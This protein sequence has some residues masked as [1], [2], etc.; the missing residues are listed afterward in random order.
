MDEER[1]IILV[2]GHE[3]LHNSQHS[4][5]E[6]NL[7]KDN[8]WKD[9]A[10][11]IHTALSGNG[12]V[13]AGSRHGNG[14][15]CVNWPLTRQGNGMVCLNRPL[16]SQPVSSCRFHQHRLNDFQQIEE[17]LVK[18]LCSTLSISLHH[19]VRRISTAQN[20]MHGSYFSMS[21]ETSLPRFFSTNLLQQSFLASVCA[22]STADTASPWHTNDLAPCCFLFS[23]G[24][25]ETWAPR[26]G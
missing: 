17:L 15:V 16:G 20:H 1:L 8:R 22:E 26:A 5:N 24:R 11:R 25:P 18:S 14:I 21:Y 19:T 23:R 13:V 4:D 3:C 2:Q 9:I 6:N 7:V 12:R 10:R